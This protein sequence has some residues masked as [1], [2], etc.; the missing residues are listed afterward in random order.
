MIKAAIVEDEQKHV[1]NLTAFLQKYGAEHAVE[2]SIEVFGDG[3]EFL[4]GYDLSTDIV[5]LDIRMP[6]MN[7]MDCARRLREMDA[8]VFLIFVTDMVQ[9][10][11]HGYEVEAIGYMVKPVKYFPFS[12]LLDKILE[13]LASREK[14]EILVTT[15]DYARRISLRDLHYVEILDHY[16]IYHTN[17]GEYREFGKLKDIEKKLSAH[18]FFRLSNSHLVNLRFVEGVEEDAAVVKG[19]MLFISRRRKKEF[20]ETLNNYMKEGGA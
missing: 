13:R 14:N 11:V 5:F 12:V 17:T 9:Y 8:E 15:K 6:H 20:L 3:V 7:G 16:L 18:G 2:F 1:Q 19:D 10:A 4:S